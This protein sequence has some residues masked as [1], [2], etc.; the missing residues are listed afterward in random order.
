[1]HAAEKRQWQCTHLKNSE[2]NLICFNEPKHS[3]ETGSAWE[4]V[5]LLS[6]LTRRRV[7]YA[8]T[9]LFLLRFSGWDANFNKHRSKCFWNTEPEVNRL[10]TQCSLKFWFSRLWNGN[11][12]RA[13]DWVGKK[14]RPYRTTRILGGGQYCRWRWDGIANH[15]P[16][17]RW[18]ALVHYEVH[19]GEHDGGSRP[20]WQERIRGCTHWTKISMWHLT[21]WHER[22][23]LG[24]FN[25]GTAQ[26]DR[27][28]LRGC[29]ENPR[30]LNRQKNRKDTR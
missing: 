18:H 9:S 26:M 13:S 25:T 1:M 30:G 6:S 15:L 3:E 2:A 23:A 12:W 14:D 27:D 21:V 11:D 16:H 17:H 28:M 24:G 5:L 4:K 29:F 7:A 19:C 22:V 8:T 20:V 10:H